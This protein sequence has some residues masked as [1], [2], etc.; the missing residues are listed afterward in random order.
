MDQIYH[1]IHF[2]NSRLRVIIRWQPLIA[3][4]P[5][6]RT[7]QYRQR[8]IRTCEVRITSHLRPTLVVYRAGVLSER[9]MA[10]VDDRLRRALGL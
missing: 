3:I 6:W 1:G 7:T 2:V 4:T 5:N 9:D 8:L 10:E